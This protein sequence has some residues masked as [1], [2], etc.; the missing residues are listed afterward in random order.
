MM[1]VT[2]EKLVLRRLESLIG[3]SYEHSTDENVLT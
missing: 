2:T 3:L 1:S